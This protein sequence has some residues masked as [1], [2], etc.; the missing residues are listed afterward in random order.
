MRLQLRA[1]ARSFVRMWVN[2][3]P[4][5]LR[6][7]VLRAQQTVTQTQGNTNY[8]RPP[9]KFTIL[10]LHKAIVVR[11]FRLCYMVWRQFCFEDKWSC[12]RQ[13]IS[14]SWVVAQR[15]MY[16]H[17]SSVRLLCKRFR[18]CFDV[19]TAVHY[20]LMCYFI[21]LFSLSL[22][23]KG[24]M[25]KKCSCKHISNPNKSQISTWRHFLSNNIFVFML[26]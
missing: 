26:L 19:F 6:G 12:R 10:Q 9:A 2:W 7:N 20:D 8:S 15:M 4:K 1:H 17:I 13:S 18:H 3:Q 21:S 24:E 16:W 5:S 23:Y 11:V 22:W 25:C 14:P